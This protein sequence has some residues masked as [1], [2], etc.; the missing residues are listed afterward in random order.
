[1]SFLEVVLLLSIIFSYLPAKD[2]LDYIS[3]GSMVYF[4]DPWWK[5]AW[6]VLPL[7]FLIFVKKRD[8]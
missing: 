4:I 8:R 3:K 6:M 5:L 7:A 2:I 1:M